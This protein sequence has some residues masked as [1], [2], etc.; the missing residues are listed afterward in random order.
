MVHTAQAR[1]RLAMVVRR[2][3]F[4]LLVL[5]TSGTTV[6]GQDATTLGTNE[7]SV[8][9]KWESL[10]ASYR[11]EVR[12]DGQ[13]FIDTEQ[14][15]S[16]LNL[17]LAPGFYE[18]RIHVLNPFGK[19]VSASEWLPLKVQSSRIPYFRVRT[20]LVIWEGDTG[21]EM[22]VESSNLREGT[23]FQLSK[24][25]RRFP[26]EWQSDGNL[27]IVRLTESAIEPGS[28]DLEAADPSGETF[29]HPDALIVRP[30]RSPNIQNLD[31]RE[32]PPEGLVPIEI[33]GEAFDSEMS[34]R[35]EGPA[36]DLPVTAVEIIE[37]NRALV[38]LDM[39][40]AQPG[41]YTLIVSNPA[42]D[43]TRKENAITVTEPVIEEIIKK[44]PRFDFQIGYAPTFIFIPDN[45]E[46]L[47]VFLG[48]DFAALFHSG[49]KAPFLRGVGLEARA[50]VGVSGPGDQGR[51]NGIGS[52]DLSGY[53][54]PLVK[55]KVAPVFLLGIGNMW[56]GY[57]KEFGIR[58]ILFIRT[59]IGMDI[60]NQRKLTRIGL[61][62]SFAS[63]NTTFPVVS[64]MFRRGIRY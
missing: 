48:F 41:D 11:I 26:T 28:W 54:R 31:T 8:T 51:I 29:V 38:Y 21:I 23:V 63:A 55:G 44:Q 46:I 5:L 39:N 27:Y 53:Y 3:L 35:F 10:E 30:T 64:L 57:A 17:N 2:S 7:G 4:I 13:V 18:Y 33:K 43:E 61:N 60:V 45:N 50:F 9:I 42:G 49:W 14:S 47:P 32:V 37:G 62:F 34:V 58:N 16:E 19:E 40:D 15:E 22:I 6:F 12:R 56:S 59:G 25:D 36:G 24:G 20:P 52:L 1:R